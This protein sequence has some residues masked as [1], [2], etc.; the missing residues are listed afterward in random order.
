MTASGDVIIIIDDDEKYD[1]PH[2]E[3]RTIT[4]TLTHELPTL[5]ST[6]E[7]ASNKTNNVYMEKKS[8][9]IN[10]LFSFLFNELR[11]KIEINC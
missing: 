8:R 7:H 10:I 1:T 11:T 4:T 5:N 2:V 9:D 3:H 6:E